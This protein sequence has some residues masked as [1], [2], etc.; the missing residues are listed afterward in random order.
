MKKALAILLALAL[1]AGAAFAEEP[2]YDLSGSASLT[3]GI[4]LN[5]NNHGFTNDASA[6]LSFPLGATSGSA[7]EE[8]IT[9]YIEISEFSVDIVDGEIDATNGDVTAKIM[10]PS[11]LYLQIASAPSFSIN[12]AQKLSTWV[13]KSWKDSKLVAPTLSSAGGFA[14]GM[15]GDLSFALKV[16]STNTH[17]S[18]A[19][20]AEYDWIDDDDDPSTA[21]VWGESEEAVVDSFDNDYMIGVDFGYTMGTMVKIAAN[22]IYGAF[23]ADPATIG[24]GLKATVTPIDGLAVVLATDV[25]SIDPETKLDVMFTADYTMADMFKFGAGAYMYK[26]LEADPTL[27]DARVRASLLAVPALTLEVGLDMLDLLAETGTYT[28]DALQMLIGAKLAYKAM[29]GE[30]NYAKPY[31]N[32]SYS[33]PSEGMYLN[34][35]LDLAVIPLTVFKLDYSAGTVTNNK[36]TVSPILGSETDKGTFTFVTTITY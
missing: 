10:F 32:V 11:N 23:Q 12:H 35:G 26:V 20:D 19:A 33:V 5:T 21:P 29:L 24:F 31:A 30:T 8:P 6:S 25:S 13:T 16:G 1:V 14:F 17:E 3:W 15:T 28:D 4:N 27:L 7:G 2:A 22:I 9:G 36:V 18:I 34:V